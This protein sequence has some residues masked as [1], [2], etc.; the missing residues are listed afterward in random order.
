MFGNVIESSDNSY[1]RGC[2]FLI[3]FY[4]R[5][6][7]VVWSCLVHSFMRLTYAIQTGKKIKEEK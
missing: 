2:L 3:R 7:K 1:A 4:F 6:Y 5:L